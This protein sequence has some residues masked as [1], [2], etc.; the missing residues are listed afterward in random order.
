MCFYSKGGQQILH[1]YR[2][3]KEYSIP[4]RPKLKA[5]CIITTK[6]RV[7]IAERINF[8]VLPRAYDYTFYLIIKH[9]PVFS[10]KCSLP[11]P[12]SGFHFSIENVSLP[13]DSRTVLVPELQELSTYQATFQLKLSYD[14]RSVG[15]S[16]LVSAS[17]LGPMTRYLYSV[18]KLRVSWCKAPF[19]TR[20]WVCNLL[21]NC[22]WTL[23]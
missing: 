4:Q 3:Y 2:C 1:G 21:Y 8:T 11:L 10:V 22:F 18:W 14:R 20:G 6:P 23:P 15:Q 9:I 19:L 13:L 12:S 16:V 7:R 5:Q 17:R